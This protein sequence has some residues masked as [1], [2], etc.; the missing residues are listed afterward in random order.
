MSNRT[1]EI[2]HEKNVRQTSRVAGDDVVVAMVVDDDDDDPDGR[3]RRPLSR[4]D[5]FGEEPLQ[6]DENGWRYKEGG[7][8]DGSPP[9]DGVAR[10]RQTAS[11]ILHL[12]VGRRA[13]ARNDCER[14]AQIRTGNDDD[15]DRDGGLQ[16]EGSLGR[17]AIA[18][19]R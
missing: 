8:D 5:P 16:R 17:L 3:R 13:A 11:W 10:R 15:G 2:S 4:R 12:N 19:G 7:D 14:S 18:G 1:T 6:E 9:G